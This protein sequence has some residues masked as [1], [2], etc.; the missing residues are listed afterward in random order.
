MVLMHVGIDGA[1]LITRFFTTAV[2]NLVK[3]LTHSLVLDDPTHRTWQTTK[4]SP[5]YA[6]DQGVA[7]STVVIQGMVEKSGRTALHS[8]GHTLRLSSISTGPRS[9]TPG[10]AS[11]TNRNPWKVPHGRHMA[12]W[13]HISLL[14]ANNLNEVILLRLDSGILTPLAEHLLSHLLKHLSLSSIDQLHGL[15]GV[16]QG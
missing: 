11:L 2:T 16:K 15:T 5:L 3:A 12:V 7:C 6:Y 14:L 9:Y 4:Q 8:A 1:D 13:D 10:T